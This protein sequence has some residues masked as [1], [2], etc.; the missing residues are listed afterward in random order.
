MPAALR[1][2]DAGSFR[3]RFGADSATLDY[4][5]DGRAGALALT[6]QAF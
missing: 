2:V 5:V 3:L 4:P 6:R 1:L